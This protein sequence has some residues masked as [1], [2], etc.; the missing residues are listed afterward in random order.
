M[1]T[2]ET[3]TRLGELHVHSSMPSKL[4]PYFFVGA[5]TIGSKYFGRITCVFGETAF[6]SLVKGLTRKNY[7]LGARRP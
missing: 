5:I 6:T 3:E 1:F 2:A 7:K 4:V